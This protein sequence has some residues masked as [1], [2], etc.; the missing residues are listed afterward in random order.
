M[1]FKWKCKLFY[2]Y[3]T[4]QEITEFGIVAAED[5]GAAAVKVS[6]R[7]GD[8]LLSLEL[9]NFIDESLLWCD[10]CVISEEQLDEIMQ[11]NW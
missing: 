7:F 3:E 5:C 6:D 11:D 10:E 9:S 2:D 4:P 1:Y 8:H